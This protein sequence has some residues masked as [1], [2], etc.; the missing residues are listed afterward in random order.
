M[1]SLLCIFLVSFL[2]LGFVGVA[3]SNIKFVCQVGTDAW[4]DLHV[5]EFAAGILHVVI[6]MFGIIPLIM[7]KVT[8]DA[9]ILANDNGPIIIIYMITSC[10]INLVW[11]GLG[12]FNLWFFDTSACQIMSYKLW[13]VSYVMIINGFCILLLPTFSFIMYKCKK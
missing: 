8:T 6:F 4:M 12:S 11:T 5:W 13:I 2:I 7:I 1:F 10:F 3:A 9:K